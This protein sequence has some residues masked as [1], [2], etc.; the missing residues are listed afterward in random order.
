MINRR[1]ILL[2]IIS[3]VLVG[4]IY[5]IFLGHRHDYTGHYAAG[6]GATYGVF[7]VVFRSLDSGRYTLLAPRLLIPICLV[8]VAAGAVAEATVFRIARFDEV[9]FCN[10]SLGAVLATAC[11][12]GH[13]ASLRLADGDYDYGLVVGIGF[14]GLG[15]VFAVA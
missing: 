8:C 7:M 2:A 3:G 14:L 13:A 9:D 10:Q 6:F 4:L 11:A 12:S 1:L 15:G 5:E